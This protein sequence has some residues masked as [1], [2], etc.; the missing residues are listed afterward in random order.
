MPAIY[1]SRRMPIWDRNYAIAMFV[2]CFSCLV[3]PTIGIAALFLVMASFKGK[4]KGIQ[5]LG[6]IVGI[7]GL[8][9]GIIV[10]VALIVTAIM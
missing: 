3:C 2:S 10:V 4:H 5:K 8:V 6:L 9:V 7:I 1:H